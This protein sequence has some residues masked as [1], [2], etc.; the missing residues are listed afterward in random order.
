MDDFYCEIFDDDLISRIAN[1]EASFAL[2]CWTLSRRGADLPGEAAFVGARPA[3]LL[4]DMLI[5]RRRADGELVYEHYGRNIA[6]QAHFDMTGRAISEFRG[7]IS[8]FF[9]HTYDRARRDRRPITTVHRLGR[10]NERPLW[11]RV[12]LPVQDP[13]GGVAFHVVNKV[14]KLE[15]DF[16]SLDARSRN[17]GVIA[18]QFVRNAAGTITDAM[19]AGANA[20]ARRMTGR[21]LDEM[22]DLSIREVFPG[23]VHLALWNRYLE[24]AATHREQSFRVE[25]R[26]DGLD[27]TFDVRL[28]PF[29]DGVAIEFRMA[30]EA[31]GPQAAGGCAA[32]DRGPREPGKP[33]K[34]AALAESSA[35]SLAATL[36]G[37]GRS[38]NDI[39]AAADP[40]RG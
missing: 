4:P 21:R 16:A 30:A 3:W 8:S 36:L 29:R 7:S 15:D 24:V 13:D 40:A 39:A 35:Q 6:A 26:L 22:L 37:C 31:A 9:Q 27:S 18:L 28:Y 14:R 33:A 5:L 1:P 32:E 10:Y 20:A 17:S 34:I 2:A 19:I 12:I 23:V 11:E 38:P 25:Y